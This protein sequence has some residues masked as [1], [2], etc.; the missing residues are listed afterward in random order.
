MLPYYLM[1]GIPLFISL[2]YGGNSQKIENIKKQKVILSVFFVILLLILVLRHRAV[3][4]DIENYLNTFLR[5]SKMSFSRIVDF[6]EEERGYYILNKLISYITTN[7]QWFI[8]IM[9]LITTI[10]LAILYI[11]ESENAMLTIATFITLSN[12]A[13]LFSGLRQAVALSIIA[14]SYY[15][16]KHKKLFWFI[17]C[18]LLA[19]TFHKSA[20][21]AILLY[22][23]Y[24]MN[25]T[26]KKLIVFV[27]ITAAILIF[28]KPIFEFLNQFM[29]E[30]GYEY[31]YKDTGAYMMIIL[32]VLFVTL[33]YI[34]PVEEELDTE[35]KGL[36][37]IAVLATM[38]QIFALTSTVAMRMN[39][40]F[41]MF[42]PI[43]I[44]RVINRTTERN[45]QPYKY[46]GI[47]MIVYFMADFIYGMHTGEDIL[48]LYP[49]RPFWN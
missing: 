10:P 21:I 28:N 3:G 16:V 9:A 47:I 17:I 35:T 20:F 27:P 13:M 42:Y 7:K 1:L 37:G 36:R 12:F 5:T 45:R 44:P 46:I 31:E 11:K 38:L 2:L 19:V 32:L 29:N 40:Y 23:F 39:Y 6:Y 15:F 26:R 8:V 43:L 24:H 25:I 14:A 49:Y 22:P 4:V 48:Q 33:S 30:L 34:A 18:V 41:M